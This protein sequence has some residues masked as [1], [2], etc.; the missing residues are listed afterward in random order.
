M[1][2]EEAGFLLLLCSFEDAPSCIRVVVVKE[3]PAKKFARKLLLTRG[4]RAFMG[5]RAS[6]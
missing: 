1:I 2:E 5:R 6:T 4:A 3:K